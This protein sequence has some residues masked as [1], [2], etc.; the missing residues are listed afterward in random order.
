VYLFATSITR[1]Y[2]IKLD[3]MVA[4][5]LLY[6]NSSDNNINESRFFQL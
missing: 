1:A 2:I 4:R 6:F 3:V 5:V